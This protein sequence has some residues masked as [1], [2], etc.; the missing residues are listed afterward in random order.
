MRQHPLVLET[1]QPPSQPSV[2][3]PAPTIPPV[4]SSTTSR[5][6]LPRA[7]RSTASKGLIPSR[8]PPRARYAEAKRS[9]SRSRSPPRRRPR[10]YRSRPR[11]KSS[12]SPSIPRS[13]IKL[14]SRSPHRPPVK[15]REATKPEWKQDD[16]SFSHWK[17]STSDSQWKQ[18]SQYYQ[19]SWSQSW[20]S[21]WDNSKWE[22]RSSSWR[23]SDAPRENRQT[24]PGPPLTAFAKKQ[25]PTRGKDTSKPPS[26]STPPPGKVP[27]ADP[28]L[29][30]EEWIQTVEKCLADTTRCPSANEIK[31]EDRPVLEEFVD[32][33]IRDNFI[34]QMKQIDSRIP[35]SKIQSLL[36]VLG[37]SGLLEAV[38]FKRVESLYL[39]NT[40]QRAMVVRLSHIKRF[41]EKPAFLNKANY[42]Y[43]MIH[44]TNIIGAK[45]CLAEALVRPADWS[46]CEFLSKCEQPTYGCFALGSCVTSREDEIPNWN[47]VDL[48]DRATTKGKGQQEILL[49]L[50]YKGAK[51]HL[52][53]K[54]GG[55]DMVQVQ[56][57]LRGV[58]TTSEK[59]TVARSEHCTIRSLIVVWPDLS[60]IESRK[61]QSATYTPVTSK[62]K[63]KEATDDSPD[64]RPPHP[65][66][67]RSWHRGRDHWDEEDET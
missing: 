61:G 28:S 50:Q 52:A 43:A 37:A 31:P 6:P 59:Y 13:D 24:P 33:P 22:T 64:D 56:C 19:S 60:F 40:S 63:S 36:Q 2:P 51:E 25:K 48:L 10:H 12:K 4:T 16:T 17:S 18:P 46:Y 29:K 49:A 21:S 38:N 32:P 57:A 14:Q 26:S 11:P 67:Y 27:L 34:T 66:T 3:T 55:N 42:S 20:D 7:A 9:P 53:L 41:E 1:P 58:V 23:S 65:D 8:S 47:L 35:A 30:D 15:L 39:P 44:G 62:D 45:Y 54:A 5:P